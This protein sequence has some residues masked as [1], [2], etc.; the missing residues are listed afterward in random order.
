M[1]NCPRPINDELYHDEWTWQDGRGRIITGDYRILTDGDANQ[2][3]DW[4]SYRYGLIDD[5]GNALLP[6]VYDELRAL[7]FDRFWAVQ[8]DRRG[9]IDSTGKWYYYVSDYGD[10]MD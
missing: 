5:D 2:T 10:L 1:A 6:Q 8:R 4:T 7:S 3:V 9:M